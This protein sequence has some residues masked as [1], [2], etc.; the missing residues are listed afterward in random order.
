VSLQKK[1][2]PGTA[3]PMGRRVEEFQNKD[4]GRR[5]WED[6]WT[7]VRANLEEIEV[8]ADSSKTTMD[9]GECSLELVSYIGI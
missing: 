7:V 1:R 5:R 4:D 9:D 2:S 6:C 3:G 8:G